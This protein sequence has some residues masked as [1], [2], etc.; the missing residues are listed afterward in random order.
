MNPDEGNGVGAMLRNAV[1]R[2]VV[3]LRDAGYISEEVAQILM[4]K[5]TVIGQQVMEVGYDTVCSLRMSRIHVDS[6]LTFLLG[7]GD[8]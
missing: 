3:Y 4:E 2:L 8:P 5:L 6:V 1:M 7:V